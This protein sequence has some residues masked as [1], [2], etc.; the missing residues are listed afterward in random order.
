MEPSLTGTSILI[1]EAPQLLSTHVHSSPNTHRVDVKA[2]SSCYLPNQ[3]PSL[4]EKESLPKISR[5]KRS[6]V[7]VLTCD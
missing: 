4:T 6:L 5:K 7:V 3:D 2:L 1:A